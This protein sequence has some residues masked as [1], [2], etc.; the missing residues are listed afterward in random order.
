MGMLQVIQPEIDLIHQPLSYYVH[1]R[2]GW[3]L[4]VALATF[5]SSAIVLGWTAARETVCPRAARWLIAFGSGMLI[6]A[7]APSD[8]WFPWEGPVSVSGSIHAIIAVIA[9]PLLLG[10]MWSLRQLTTVNRLTQ[11]S[12][13][14]LALAYGVGLMTSAISLVVGF[15]T[16]GAPPLIGLTERILAVAAVIWLALAAAPRMPKVQ[17]NPSA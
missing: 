15:I 11:I 1:G 13:N 4:P 2:Y 9:P 8:R 7:I 5:G 17:T 3:L 6:A 16:D 12:L 10:A 14:L